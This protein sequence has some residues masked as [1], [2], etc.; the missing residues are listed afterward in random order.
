MARM[1]H[2]HNRTL[3]LLCEHEILWESRK[4]EPATPG[5]MLNI[6]P[7]I[8]GWSFPKKGVLC[9]GMVGSISGRRA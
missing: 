3:D 8:H 1:S 5:L 9:G 4:Q 6:S 7:A 2:V